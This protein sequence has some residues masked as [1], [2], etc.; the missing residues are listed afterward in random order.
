[1]DVEQIVFELASQLGA[2]P[3]ACGLMHAAE[4]CCSRGD[5]LRWQRQ[6]VTTAP[7]PRCACSPSTGLSDLCIH[8]GIENP[9][10]GLQDRALN[11][12]VRHDLQRQR[13]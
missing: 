12:L 3:V 9:A 4:G 5:G 8:S 7:S 6:A 11:P 1:M 10:L 2:R 13:L